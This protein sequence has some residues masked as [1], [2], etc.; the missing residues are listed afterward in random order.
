M[1]EVDDYV[2]SEIENRHLKNSFE[3]Y[4]KIV[5]EVEASIGITPLA[6]GDHRLMVINRWIKHVIIPQRKIEQRRKELLSSA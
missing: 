4:A 6:Q 2:R 5:D 1:Q 3:A